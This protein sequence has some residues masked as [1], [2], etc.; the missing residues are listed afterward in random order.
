MD[1]WI[2]LGVQL[3]IV[4]SNVWALIL[5]VGIRGTVLIQAVIIDA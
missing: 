5:T 3:G 1:G 2:E 4:M